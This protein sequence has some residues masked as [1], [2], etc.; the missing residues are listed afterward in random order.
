MANEPIAPITP[1]A[2]K[3]WILDQTVMPVDAN[4]WEA[5]IIGLQN[6]VNSINSAFNPLL[7]PVGG[8]LTGALKE[9]PIKAITTAGTVTLT[10][11]SNIFSV[12]GTGPVASITGW[13]QGVAIIVWGSALALTNGA[14]LL[15][16]GGSR[17]VAVGDVSFFMFSGAVATELIYMPA[18]GWASRFLPFAGGNMAGAINEAA[19]TMASASTMNIGAAAGNVITVTG[20][21]NITAFDVAP[22][23]TRRKLIFSEALTLTHNAAS[24]I[25]PGAQ[26]LPVIAGDSIEVVS[27]GGGTWRILGNVANAGQFSASFAGNGYQKL[28]GGFIIQWGIDITP[29]GS[30]N[31]G[32]VF[33]VTFPNTC[34]RVVA[35]TGGANVTIQMGEA[36]AGGV[37]MTA[38]AASTGAAATSINVAYI[39][40]GY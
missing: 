31:I 9:A 32:F 16:K 40:I 11:D 37:A 26:N 15:L 13:A 19:V 10:T 8:S 29:T 6:A 23:G 3:N 17:N 36:Y 7:T 38:Y 30:G 4:G 18:A 28:P 1:M 39:A 24:L 5:A 35:G 22:A 27:L 20:S 14:N 33:P 25:V 12:T 21:N 2:A 34:L